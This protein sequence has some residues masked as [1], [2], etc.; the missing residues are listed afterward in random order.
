VMLYHFFTFE[1]DKKIKEAEEKTKTP[2]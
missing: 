1:I 2:N